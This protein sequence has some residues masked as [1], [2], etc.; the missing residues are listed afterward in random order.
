MS[1][2]WFHSRRNSLAPLLLAAILFAQGLRLCLH[3]PHDVEMGHT[4]TTALHIENDL[5]AEDDGSDTTGDRH[6]PLGLAFIKKLANTILW[7][8]PFAVAL[9]FALPR[10]I[11]RSLAE[12]QFFFPSAGRHRRRP[13]L[14]A[15]PR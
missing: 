11:D 10:V 2:A 1:L 5:T 12:Q 6:V 7:T 4:H 3:A 14:R 9:L 8:V 15:P 13:P